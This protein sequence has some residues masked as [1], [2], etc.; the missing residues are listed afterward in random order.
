MKYEA[1]AG[2]RCRSI[3]R[4]KLLCQNQKFI[5]LAYEHKVLNSF[6]ISLHILYVH[7]TV[8]LLES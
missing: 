4:V 2:W 8:K 1:I 6:F 7:L 3:Y 5:G